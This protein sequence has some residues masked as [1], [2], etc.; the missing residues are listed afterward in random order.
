MVKQTP[1]P[2]P[3]PA[4]FPKN[5]L[6]APSGR[7]KAEEFVHRCHG[8]RTGYDK[9]QVWTHKY[10]TS[11]TLDPVEYPNYYPAWDDCFVHQTTGEE[12]YLY[13]PSPGDVTER[14]RDDAALAISKLTGRPLLVIRRWLGLDPP[15]VQAHLEML[16]DC[17]TWDNLRRYNEA[18]AK[19]KEY[20]SPASES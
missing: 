6:V 7:L 11:R 13:I 4:W 2:Y 1:R 14:V 8:V 5:D 18:V 9:L 15:D 10:G 20:E 19:T 12:V 16:T 17:P 3:D